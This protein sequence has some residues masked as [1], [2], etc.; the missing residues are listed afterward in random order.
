M[1]RTWK[2][3]TAG[4]LNL[5]GGILTLIAGLSL[6]LGASFVAT[7]YTG[8]GMPISASMLSAMAIPNVVLGILAVIGGVFCLKRNHWGWALTGSIANVLTAFILGVLAIIFVAMGKN[9]FE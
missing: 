1:E 2:P 6:L 4:I 3:V 8:L 5:V 7:F 9:E